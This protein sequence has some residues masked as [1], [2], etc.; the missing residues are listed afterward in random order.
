MLLYPQREVITISILGERIRMLRKAHNLNQEELSAALNQRFGLRTDRVMISKWET[1][2]QTPVMNTITCLAKYFN[3]S[4]D[5]LND[6]EPA[7]NSFSQTPSNLLPLTV[8]N[9]EGID[10]SHNVNLNMDNFKEINDLIA[11]VRDL[12]PEKI[13]AILQL[14]KTLK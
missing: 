6:N 11:E 2:F 1:G 3:V 8:Y 4:L 10:G 7:N 5:F 14:V 13:K 12:P 9:M